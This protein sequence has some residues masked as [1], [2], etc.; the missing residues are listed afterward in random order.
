MTQG[1]TQVWSCEECEF[2]TDVAAPGSD[3]N[4]H[5]C[6]HPRVN[7]HSQDNWIGFDAITPSWCPFLKEESHER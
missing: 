3:L 5:Y 7:R 4:H 1:P 2:H 6:R